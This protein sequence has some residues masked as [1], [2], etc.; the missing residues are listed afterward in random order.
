MV[1]MLQSWDE[2]EAA[3]GSLFQ[4]KNSINIS[5]NIPI[6]ISFFISVVSVV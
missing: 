4:K 6:F 5:I 1:D 2:A 3:Q